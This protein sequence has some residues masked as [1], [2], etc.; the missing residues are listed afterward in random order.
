LLTDDPDISVRGIEQ[1]R[2]ARALIMV[3]DQEHAQAQFHTAQDLLGDNP[4]RLADVS[5][6][7]A[8]TYVQTH[9]YTQALELLESLEPTVGELSHDFLTARFHSVKANALLGLGRSAD[10]ETTVEPAIA[11]A[12]RGLRSLS[13]EPD[14]LDWAQTFGAAYKTAIYTKF[15]RDPTGALYLWEAFKSASRGTPDEGSIGELPTDIHKITLPTKGNALVSYAIFPDGLVL[16]TADDSG[17]R[18]LWIEASRRRL[19]SV[20]RRFIADC[21]DPDS[22]KEEI[23][24][25][26]KDLYS[27]L[28]EPAETWIHGHSHLVIETDDFLDGLPFEALVDHKQQFL[29]ESYSISYSPGSNSIRTR[30][31]SSR[32]DRSVRALVVGDPII[33]GIGD[34]PPLSEALEESGDVAA[35]F[36]NSHVLTRDKATLSNIVR[37][38]PAAEVFHFAGHGITSTRSAGLLLSA[39]GSKSSSVL[40]AIEVEP[41]LIPHLRLVV[42]SA[43]SSGRGTVHTINDRDG[44]ARRFVT[45]G[46]PTVVASRWKVDSTVARQWM[47]V[48]YQNAT[49]GQSTS[50]AARISATEIRRNTKWSHPF[51]WCA[52]TVF[53]ISN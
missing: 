3:G 5:I 15:H 49:N 53:G 18:V 50:D 39:S 24:R 19:E 32:I 37:E 30:K 21:G 8:D 7:L 42:L 12:T 13:R 11:I 4:P 41:V 43:C 6:D 20:A 51:Y 9:K 36:G 17:V 34:L 31:I 1:Y 14:R 23:T 48:F 40:T 44:L 28:L 22:S 45:L 27:L 25:D 47:K 46:V 10:A 52:F 16:W 29:G 35:V 2:L 33:S 26:A 38:L